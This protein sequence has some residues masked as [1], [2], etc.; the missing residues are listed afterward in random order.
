LVRFESL[1]KEMGGVDKIDI[2]SLSS[3]DRR[4]F[5]EAQRIKEAT[6]AM[7]RQFTSYAR[8][9]TLGPTSIRGGD[10]LEA[11]LSELP[12]DIERGVRHELKTADWDAF[13]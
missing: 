10:Y 2:G 6:V 12:R 4:S 8:N 3:V 11:C 7:L 1:A 5:K 9:N 13:F